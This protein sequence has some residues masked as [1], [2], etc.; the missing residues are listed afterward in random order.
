[1]SVTV[2]DWSASDPRLA[3]ELRERPV[4]EALGALV[5][6]E[7]YAGTL[8]CDPAQLDHYRFN[9]D[10]HVFDLT[11]QV[12]EGRARRPI[13]PSRASEA[14]AWMFGFRAEEYRPVVE[15]WLP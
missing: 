11:V 3:A 4:A 8:A 14:V 6:A 7:R 1:M 10:R 13:G 9:D 2:I 5:E 12:N 15:T